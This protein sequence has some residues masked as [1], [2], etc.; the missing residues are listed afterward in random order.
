[1]TLLN[2]YALPARLFFFSHFPS[3]VSSV[4]TDSS[5]ERALGRILQSANQVARS[6]TV[7]KYAKLSKMKNRMAIQ[8]RKFPPENQLFLS[9]NLFLGLLF[10]VCFL[11]QKRN[12]IFIYTFD[13]LS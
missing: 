5:F 8:E 13:I 9:F 11:E 2:S 6:L 1:M 4:R 7:K 10:I 12:G 3:E